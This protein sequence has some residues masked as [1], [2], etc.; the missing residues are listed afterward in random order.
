MNRQAQEA[1]AGAD[2]AK[3]KADLLSTSA[4][5]EN[6][7]VAAAM[8]AVSGEAPKATSAKDRLAALRR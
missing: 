2:A 4:V 5:E 1:Q 8:A 7:A 6:D 3:R